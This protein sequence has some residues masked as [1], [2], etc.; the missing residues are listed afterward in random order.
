MN[1]GTTHRPSYNFWLLNIAAYLTLLTVVLPILQKISPGRERTVL[2]VLFLA[3]ALLLAFFLQTENR[4]VLVYG[5]LAAQTALIL[6]IFLSNPAVT[7][8]VPVLF[9]VL[10]A[11]AMLFL[12][13]TAGI[14]WIVAFTL[15]TWGGTV[16]A[17]GLS[18]LVEMLT[19]GGGFAFFGSFGAI[20]R[21]A[22]QER[23]RSQALLAELQAAHSRLK[24]YAQQVAELAVAEERNRLAREMHDALGHRLTVAVV[25]LEGSQRLIPNDPGRAA[26]MVGAMR[27][28][29]KEALTELRQTVAQLRADSA[30]DRPLT[31]SLRQLALSFQEATGLPV[32]L[33]LPTDFPSLPAGQRLA[34]YRA[35]QE[36]L[37]NVHKHA[38]AKQLWLTLS[39]AD[40]QLSLVIED[41]GLGLSPDLVPGRY[42]LRGL[43]ERAE[44]LG[45]ACNCYTRPGGGTQLHFQIPL[46]LT[47]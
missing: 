44:Q 10:S 22:N 26:Q 34:L 3:F 11:Q 35:A 14:G 4:P 38:Q 24:D 16:Y 8:G 27:E 15:L 17:V 45:G 46:T 23:E 12:P 1:D 9:F 33:A 47:P 30:T 43:Q 32:Q 36:G 18:A 19:I 37:T 42:G 20:L 29:L 6:A 41:D 21:Q 7:T 40:G 5:Y 39:P 25:Q 28:Q 13:L 31:D 2:I